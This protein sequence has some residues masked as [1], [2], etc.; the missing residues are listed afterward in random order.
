MTHPIPDLLHPSPS[1]RLDASGLEQAVAFAFAAGGTAETFSRLLDECRTARSAYRSG[2]FSADLFLSD[3][4]ARCVPLRIQGAGSGVH[5]GA[6]RRVLESPPAD[7]ATIEFRHRVLRELLDNPALRRSCEQAWA[8]IRLLRRMLE[9]AQLGK[10]RNDI[11]RRVEILRATR[12]VIDELAAGFGDADSALARL[13]DYAAELRQS[14]GY[15]HLHDLLDYEGHLATM[16]VRLRVG[17]DGHLRGFELVRTCENTSNPFYRSPLSRFWTWLRALLRGYR[18]RQAEVLGTMVEA[19]FDGV[20]D[21]FLYLFQ[22]GCDLEFYLAALAFRDFAQSRGLEVCLPSFVQRGGLVATEMTRLFNPFLLHEPNPPTPCDL[23]IPE[24]ALVIITGPNSGGKTRLLQAAGLAQLLGQAGFFVPAQAA[25]LAWREGLFVSLMHGPAS[26]QRE[27]RLGTEL[28]RIRTVFEQLS[29]ESLVLLDELCAGTNP[30][31]GIELF[32]LVVSLLAQLRPQALITT[33]FLDFAGRLER[34]RPIDG[35]EFLQVELDEHLYPTYRFIPGVA[36]T[37]LAKK[38][39]ERRGVTRDALLSIIERK[40]AHRRA[41]LPPR[42]SEP[43]E[44]GR[45]STH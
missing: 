5:C 7:P 6:L 26:D 39:A 20:R 30:S 25:R 19:V 37:S 33:H 13:Y 14:D 23:R 4:V 10:Y 31:E 34:E 41:Q 38:T 28:L 35:L 36:P 16:D 42:D 22:V 9:A 2:C 12:E 21:T 1:L 29:F 3:F 17:Y 40:I 32:E 43:G 18:F 8:R 44:D 11:K 15:G 45:P 24:G 27:G